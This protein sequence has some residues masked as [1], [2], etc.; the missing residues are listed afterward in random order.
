MTQ[1]TPAQRAQIEAFAKSLLDEA[2]ATEAT[3][4]ERAEAA[5][6][7]RVETAV[8]STVS[9]LTPQQRTFLVEYLITNNATGAA[10]AAGYKNPNKDGPRLR[11]EPF[12]LAALNDYFSG[13]EMSAKEVVARLSEQARAEYAPYFRIRGDVGYID[14]PQLLADGKG[15]LVKGIKDTQWG[16]QVE[17]YDAHTALV[18]VGRV[19][20]IFTDKTDVT[21]GGEKLGQPIVIVKGEEWEAL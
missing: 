13:A 19:H 17:F 14:L 20:G 5:K 18:D 15:H 1:F 2:Q 21:S 3:I 10:R 8:H 12:I 9:A 11:K 4:P 7:Q 6:R 16:Q